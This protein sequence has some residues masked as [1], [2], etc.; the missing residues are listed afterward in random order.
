MT[1]T[2][3][4]AVDPDTAIDE[5]GDVPHSDRRRAALSNAQLAPS[6]RRRR[7]VPGARLA[8]HAA[9]VA[10]IAVIAVGGLWAYNNF[11]D[12]A[13]PNI[14][15]AQAEATVVPV[16]TQ[17]IEIR[18]LVETSRLSGTLGFDP[19]IAIT[20]RVGGSVSRA[21]LAGSSV[22]RG[23]ELFRIDGRPT[24]AF[25]GESA[26][27]R[28]LSATS[29]ADVDIRQLEE[30]LAVLGFDPDHEMTI[31]NT[32]TAATTSAVQRWQ[33]DRGM[34]DDGIVRISDVVFVSG[35]GEITRADAT[36]GVGVG[37]GSILLSYQ[38]HTAV[39]AVL[40][41]R[42]GNVTN[43]APVGSMVAA[44]QE[45]FSV[46]TNVTY[47]LIADDA[48]NT[49]TLQAGVVDGTDIRA[50]E[51]NLVALGYDP[52]GEIEVDL[53]WEEATT[54][55]VNWTRPGSRRRRS[56]SSS[57]PSRW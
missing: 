34:V 48:E 47:A 45:L 35:P 31:D 15:V 44:G 57:S 43:L 10:L 6:R 3:T 55:A 8:K 21:P 41:Y 28:Q 42:E 26:A 24:V 52:D 39:D 49:R 17:A 30:N 40:G 46:N 12:P 32:W 29:A 53:S 9:V 38:V 11:F 33:S 13:E 4:P 14:A 1:T 5:L 56:S 2:A 51:Q 16:A 23:T 18:D 19:A 22:E 37:E 7:P 50:L 54:D 36:S 25:F 27:W 20:S